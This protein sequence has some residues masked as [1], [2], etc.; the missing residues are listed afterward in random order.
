MAKGLLKIQKVSNNILN[1][2]KNRDNEQNS[3]DKKR[4]KDRSNI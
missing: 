1:L 3:N 2:H 4:E